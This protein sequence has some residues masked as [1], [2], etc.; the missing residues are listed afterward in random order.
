MAAAEAG[1]FSRLQSCRAGGGRNL[2]PVLSLG[3]QHLTGVFPKTAD[4]VLTAGPLELVWCPESGLLQL[5]HS[6]DPDE[7]YGENYGYRSSLNRSM[8]DHLAR[9]TRSAFFRSVRTSSPATS[10]WTSDRTTGPR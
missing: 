8:A 10:S 5:A 2:L 9:K 7:L 6:Y 1:R 3:H 4:E